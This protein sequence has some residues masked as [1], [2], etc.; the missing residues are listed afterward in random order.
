MLTRL[1]VANATD[2]TLL[3]VAIACSV[4]TACR[5]NGV[6]VN[7]YILAMVSNL[8]TF[9]IN[10]L[11]LQTVQVINTAGCDSV[12][13][14]QLSRVDNLLWTRLAVSFSFLLTR[15]AVSPG[16]EI[17]LLT[18]PAVS[19]DSAMCDLFTER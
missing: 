7:K 6:S 16:Q 13:T 10:F 18:R 12:I 8:S 3:A 1:A 9:E 17:S 14:R 15:P 19:L 11:C 4:D 5:G 2:F